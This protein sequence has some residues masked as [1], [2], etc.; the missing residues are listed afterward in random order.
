MRIGRGAENP[1]RSSV[2]PRGRRDGDIADIDAERARDLF[3]RDAV[4]HQGRDPAV[5]RLLGVNRAEFD[6]PIERIVERLERSTRY[7][8]LQRIA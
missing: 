3:R 2:A 4:G 1:D 7:G 5:A 8:T 6:E